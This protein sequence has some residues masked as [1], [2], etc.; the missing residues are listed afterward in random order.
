MTFTDLRAV[1]A[2]Y[3]N[4]SSS[5]ALERVGRSINRHYKRV[6]ASLGLDAVRHVTRSTTTTNGQQYVVFTEIEYIARVIDAT[7]SNAIRV[8]PEISLDLQRT[9]QPGT[10]QPTTWALRNTDA[11][12]VTILLDTLPQT[13]YSLQADGTT[14]LSALSGSDEPVFPESYHDI[15]SWYV[16][17][18]ELL[19]KEKVDLA[20][21]YAQRADR[22]LSE[23][24]HYL[25]DSPSRD[26]RQAAQ[27]AVTAPGASGGGGSVGGTAYTQSAL[28]TF[29]QN[30]LRL[31]DTDES[32]GVTVN[33]GSNITA[34]R[35]L[36]LVTGDADRTITLSGNPTLDNWFDQSVKT[37]ASPTFVS[38]IASTSLIIGAATTSGI[39][40]DLESGTLAV[41]EGDDTAYGPVKALTL[42]STTT[43]TVGTSLT[44]TGG[45]IVFPATQNASAGA[46]TLDDYEEGAVTSWDP[47]IGGAG[48]TSGQ[49]YATQ[50][51]FYT[52]IGNIVIAEFSVQLSVEGTITGDVQIQG[53]P[54]T[55]GAGRIDV[56][57]VRFGSLA[58]N[59]ISIIGLAVGSSTAIALRGS[60]A[61]GTSSETALT[62]ADIGN[63]TFFNGT[64]VYA[65]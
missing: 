21:Q 50:D 58:T 52:K 48:G 24:R 51:G 1:V 16:I 6:T 61:A 39:R 26:T 31:L 14:T 22:L 4:L 28:L 7:D 59:W 29:E 38:P 18:E 32:H 65:V 3:C 5:E 54:F 40:L 9:S 60:Q 64:I 23:L 42:E 62:A 37:S 34:E 11:D 19:R 30:T 49:T 17:S 56:C 55:V 46:N 15:L 2:D 8:L 43:A 13:S 57:A 33:I 10:S 44:V 25:A 27:Q 47:V 45:Q 63:S 35:A 41:R 36:S 53:L 12:S 20:D